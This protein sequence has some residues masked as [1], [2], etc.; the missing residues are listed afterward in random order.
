MKAIDSRLNGDEMHQDENEGTYKVV[1]PLGIEKDR[2]LS[3]ISYEN[4]INDLNVVTVA[5]IQH[6]DTGWFSVI[7]AALKNR[8]PG[9]NI[10]EASTFGSTHGADHVEMFASLPEKLRAHKID[11]VISGIGV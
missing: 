4:R 8:Y 9:I 2:A 10:V 11:A 7:R 6:M 1:S 3:G 5:E